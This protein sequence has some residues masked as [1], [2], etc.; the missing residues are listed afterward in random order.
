MIFNL[1]R[2]LK[3]SVTDGFHNCG[4]F[5]TDAPESV[6]EETVNLIR[7]DNKL[8][9]SQFGDSVCTILKARG[10]YCERYKIKSFG[11]SN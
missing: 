7:S 3:D 5:E 10:Y 6:I 9:I 1:Y 8:E 4:Y 11:Y 2:E